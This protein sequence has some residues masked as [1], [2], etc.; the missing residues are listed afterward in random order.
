[1]IEVVPVVLVVMFR[2]C[3][4]VS[5]DRTGPYKYC[6]IDHCTRYALNLAFTAVI[7]YTLRI[8]ASKMNHYC[9]TTL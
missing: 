9:T 1:M 4:Y 8:H 5:K 3:D 6:T 2:P 7:I